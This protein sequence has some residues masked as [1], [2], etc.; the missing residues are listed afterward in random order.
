[1][2]FKEYLQETTVNNKI[3]IY[4]DLDM[5][6]ANFIKEFMKHNPSVK[7]EDVI[8]QSIPD[9]TFWPM[10][11]K[12][13]NFWENLEPMKNG[14]ALMDWACK[15][16]Y[17]VEILSSPSRH[18]KRSIKGKHTWVKKYLSKYSP[19]VN[20]V[21]A[22]EKQTFS[23]E[24]SILVDDLEKNIK[25][26]KSKGGKGLLFKDNTSMLNK[27]KELVNDIKKTELNESTLLLEKQL[28]IN[29]GAKYGQVVFLAGGGGSGKG[30][31]L[32]NFME[33]EKFKVMDV[34]ELKLQFIK[35]SKMKDKYP[36]IKNLD[37]RNPNHVFKLHTFIK[38][39]KIKDKKLDNL[40]GSMS[41][42]I[43]PNIVFDIT[44]KDIKD[45]TD[46][47]PSLLELGYAPKDIHLVWV[48]TNFHVAVKQNAERARVVPDDI[49]LKTH[50]G[51]ANTMWSIIS[52]GRLPKGMDGGFYI[53]MNNKENTIFYTNADGEKIKNSKGKFIIKDFKYVTVKKPTKAINKNAKDDLHKQI[54]DNIPRTQDTKDIWKD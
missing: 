26:F 10:V 25:Q 24:N 33:K 8:N 9:D 41:K 18:D 34:D 4:F 22:S 40:F 29:N 54:I 38:D 37:L 47:L 14:I 31:A 43:L 11:Q 23:N 6:L 30:F 20:L 48:L 13:N 1:M 52:K 32:E 21:R 3:T 7:K 42:G 27:L 51:A 45:I 49:M 46:Y 19:K 2:S 15:E 50:S 5:T 36:E 39:K 16:G 44:S 28:L 53:I 35:I 17:N 12:I